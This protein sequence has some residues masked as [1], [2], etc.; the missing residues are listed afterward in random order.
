MLE[1]YGV[2][3]DRVTETLDAFYQ[4]VTWIM[5]NDIEILMYALGA[6]F[7][8]S[9]LLLHGYPWIMAD[10][11]HSSLSVPYLQ[12]FWEQSFEWEF[13]FVGPPYPKFLPNEFAFN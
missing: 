8:G 9:W 6:S 7:P 4:E 10:A 1:I 5:L 12:E 2:Y 3:E 13:L 11:Y